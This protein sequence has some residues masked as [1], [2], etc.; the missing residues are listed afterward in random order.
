MMGIT[1]EDVMRIAE[2]AR[3]EFG[4]EEAEKFASQLGDIL[5]Y[6]AKL[7]EI[8]TKGK[9]PLTHAQEMVNV[10]RED[11]PVEGLTQEQALMNAPQR[12]GEFF[13]V[14]RIMDNSQE[15]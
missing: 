8:D 12:K 3:L 5:G 14:P 13:L 9:E 10:M 2:L 4:P 11:V 6:A 15:D 7:D 1:K